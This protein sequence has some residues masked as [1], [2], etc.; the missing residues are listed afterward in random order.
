MKGLAQSVGARLLQKRRIDEVTFEACPLFATAANGRSEWLNTSVLAG[1]G[2]LKFNRSFL[3]LSVLQQRGFFG[4]D[5]NFPVLTFMDLRSR[6][7]PVVVEEQIGRG[8][9]RQPDWRILRS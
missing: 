3:R 7:G 4:T 2:V 5:L 8:P 6:P 9:Q 1:A